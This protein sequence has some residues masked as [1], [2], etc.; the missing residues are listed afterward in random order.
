VQGHSGV[1][2]VSQLHNKRRVN[3]RTFAHYRTNQHYETYM[4]GGKDG[5]F[6]PRPDISDQSM[7]TVT[8]KMAKVCAA[9][10]HPTTHPHHVA[11]ALHWSLRSDQR[12]LLAAH[13]QEASIALRTPWATDFV[14]DPRAGIEDQSLKLSF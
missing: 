2:T 3:N 9:L 7:E 1:P 10:W 13:A 12:G 14:A 4:H 8:P 5:F 11:L 6:G